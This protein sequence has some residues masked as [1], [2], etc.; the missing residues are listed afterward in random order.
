MTYWTP[1]Q[2]EQLASRWGGMTGK[3]ISQEIFGTPYMR[4]AV[5]AKARRMGLKKFDNPV[6]AIQWDDERFRALWNRDVTVTR[7][8]HVFKCGNEAV[9]KHARDLKLP[10]REKIDRKSPRKLK[11]SIIPQPKRHP[12][13]PE[14]GMPLTQFTGTPRERGWFRDSKDCPCGHKMP[15]GGNR[16]Y[17]EAHE[18]S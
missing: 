14:D 9:R 1:H 12:V 6:K 4:S 10:A 2:K 3:Q 5:I 16:C 8:G 11:K 18:R 7:L 13:K 15:P 17:G